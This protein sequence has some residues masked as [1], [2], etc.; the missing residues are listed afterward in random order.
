M[1][2]SLNSGVVSKH[3][4]QQVDGLSAVERDRKTKANRDLQLRF[5]HLDLAFDGMAWRVSPQ[6]QSGFADCRGVMSLDEL[7]DVFEILRGE[8]G[9]KSKGKRQR[10]VSFMQR[11]RELIGRLVVSA[12]EHAHDPTMASVFQRLIR[13]FEV[14]EVTMG[15]EHELNTF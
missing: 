1:Q 15:V 6:V 8:P 5:E 13:F 10:G 4:I 14:R 3:R 11:A 7:Q 9:M 12:R 2:R